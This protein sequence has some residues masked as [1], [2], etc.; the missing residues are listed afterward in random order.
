VVN[1]LLNAEIIFVMEHLKHVPVVLGIVVNVLQN[2]AIQYVKLPK[3]VIPAHQIVANVFQSAEIQYVIF[4]K[5]VLLVH[6]IAEIARQFVVITSANRAKHAQP[7]L[8][9]V[10]YVQG[11]EMEL[12]PGQKT[13]GHA[14]QIV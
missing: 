3:H 11:A 13:A 4:L 6:K 14:H 12:V 2:V 8:M 5:V 7:V 10:D 9:T 1:V